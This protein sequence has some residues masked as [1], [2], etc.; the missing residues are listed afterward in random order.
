[1]KNCLRCGSNSE[2][3]SIGTVLYLFV[4]DR[5]RRDTVSWEWKGKEGSVPVTIADMESQSPPELPKAVQKGMKGKQVWIVNKTSTPR[6]RGVIRNQR[7][8]WSDGRQDDS[9]KCDMCLSPECKY[10]VHTDYYKEVNK[11]A[12]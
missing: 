12:I 7:I 2:V 11:R 9:N 6:E 8:R 1:M 5:C 10:P 4:C 3:S